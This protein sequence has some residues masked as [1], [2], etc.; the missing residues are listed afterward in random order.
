M[1]RHS[2]A[3][4]VLLYLY[5]TPL[6]SL[7][8][9]RDTMRTESTRQKTSDSLAEQMD[10]VDLVNKL[11]NA[12]LSSKSDT[13]KLQPGKLYLALV[14]SVGY[15]L[16]GNWLANVSVNT[17]FYTANPALTNLSTLNYGTQYDLNH[18]LIVPITS[19]I[20]LKNNTINLLGDWRYYKYPSYTYGLGGNTLLSNADLINYSY[21]RFCQEVLGHFGSFFYLGG[22]YN[23]D[24]HFDITEEGS[25][26]DFN[27]Y[28]KDATQTISSGPIVHFAYDSRSNI[29]NPHNA[30]YGSVSYRYNA[31]SL[32]STQQWQS[33]FM[34]LKKYV[35]L[36]PSSPN[37]LALWSWNVFTFGGNAPYFDLP[38]NGWDVNNNSGRGYIQGR[39]RGKNMIYDEAEY[40]FRVTK[41]GLLGGVIFANAESVSQ[42]P[43]NKFEYINPGYGLGVRLKMNKY[44]D[45][46]LCFDYGF[47]LMGS[48]G[49][50]F[51]LGEVF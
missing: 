42:Y 51:N 43:D 31:V 8:Q 32:G 37:V 7:A 25:N 4:L 44:S 10:A 9:S 46:N 48:N 23:Y 17:S 45:V 11:F 26:V 12:H 13:Q 47:G 24:N 35:Q 40:R 41:N 36:S 15:T 5:V 29:N 18:Q 19:D 1:N 21:F 34:E 2:I 22:G 20:W 6:V 30:F 3:F 39:F 33:A 38:S 49:I 14:P 16:E 27:L 28:N 50:F